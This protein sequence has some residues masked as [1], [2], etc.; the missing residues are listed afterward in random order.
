MISPELR[1]M[2]AVDA[3]RRRTG[4]CPTHI[5]ALGT[6]ESSEIAPRPDGFTDLATGAK[7]RCEPMLMSAG[8]FGTVSITLEGDV[9]FSGIETQSG[10][11]FTGRAGGGTTV[12]IYQSDDYFQ[13]A[14][15]TPEQPLDR[16]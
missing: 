14:V 8:G 9:A 12:T 15:V 16:S 11:R 7:I 13:Y 5:H 3:H 2:I 1:R 10:Q 6:G 4:H